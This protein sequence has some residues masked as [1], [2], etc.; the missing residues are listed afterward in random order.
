MTKKLYRSE[1]DKVFLG[2]LGGLSEYFDVDP[3]VYRLLFLFFIFITG[4]FPGV[5]FYFVAGL[6]VP[7]RKF[8]NFSSEEKRK[9]VENEA[10]QK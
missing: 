2:I 9:T 8:E 10:E 3:T 4:L 1:R 6:I 5:I 7:S